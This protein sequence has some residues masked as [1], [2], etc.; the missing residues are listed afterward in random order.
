M[1]LAYGLRFL[2]YFYGIKT[3]AASKCRPE[4]LELIEHLKASGTGKAKLVAL[5][6]LGCECP[7]A[8]EFLERAKKVVPEGTMKKIMAYVAADTPTLVVAPPAPKTPETPVVTPPTPEAK[9]NDNPEGKKE[10]DKGGK[11]KKDK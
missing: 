7:D 10:D 6:K 3:M 11:G 2:H 5:E 1:A 4:V 9:T 8:K